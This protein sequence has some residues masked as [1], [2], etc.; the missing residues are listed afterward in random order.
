MSFEGTSVLTE[1]SE[2]RTKYILLFNEDDSE[3]KFL[4]TVCLN[5]ES[6]RFNL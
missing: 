6:F 3:I 2:G 1:R 4:N 5:S